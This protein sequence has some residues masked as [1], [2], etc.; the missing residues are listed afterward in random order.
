[1]LNY[2]EASHAMLWCGK[3]WLITR[4]YLDE[5][6]LTLSWTDDWSEGWSLGRLTHFSIHVG[7]VWLLLSQGTVWLITLGVGSPNMC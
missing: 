3:A 1:M 2:R 5:V 7:G 6:H 4:N